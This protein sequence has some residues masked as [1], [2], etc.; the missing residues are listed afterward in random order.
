MGEGARPEPQARLVEAVGAV[1]GVEAA[2]AL[3]A[4]EAAWA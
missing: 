3:A 1:L 2:P 4:L